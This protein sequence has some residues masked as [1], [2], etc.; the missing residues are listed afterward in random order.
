MAIK[1]NIGMIGIG[2]MG[3]GI[4]KNLLQKGY[5][6]MLLEHPGNQPV[7]DLLA[8]GARTTALCKELANTN[9]VI[10]ICVTGSQQVE[11]VV[12]GKAGIL[13]GLQKGATVIDCSTIEPHVTPRM[14]QAVSGHG[15]TYLDAPLTRTPKEAEAGRLNVMV[16]GDADQVDLIRPILAAFCENIYHA[17]PVAS[18]HT[19]K[20]LHNFIS[21]TN[22][23]LLAE[24]VV[25]AQRS[26]ISLEVLTEVLASG[27]GGSTALQRLIPYLQQSDSSSF[28]FSL[29]NS[30]KDLSYYQAFAQH[31]DTPRELA[32]AAAATLADNVDDSN[33]M[34]PLPTLI[35]IL[36][37][38]K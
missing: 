23:L 26:N 19:L 34:Q 1:Q 17:G 38:G 20:L 28:R 13:S 15:G 24:A 9:T 11:E 30:L 5:P 35:D 8:M 2:L 7:Q 33:G 12:T 25:C 31:I 18:G 4:A 16:G 14:A 29:A 37:S 10:I 36:S 32:D 21:L 27:G 6:V 3:H 22:C